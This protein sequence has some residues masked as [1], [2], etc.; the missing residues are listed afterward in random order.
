M[1]PVL[2]RLRLPAVL[3][4]LILAVY[5]AQAC[6]D[7]GTSPASV[8]Q[9]AVSPAEVQLDALEAT[10]QLEAAAFDESGDDVPGVT[11]TWSSSDESVV[12]VDDSGLLT[13]VGQGSATVTAEARGVSGTASV[14]VDQIVTTVSLTP[15]EASVA[16]GQSVDFDA[17]ASDENGHP[18]AD[19]L[20]TWTSSDDA[21]ATVDDQGV[22]TGVVAGTATI[23]AEAASGAFEEAPLTVTA[24]PLQ[25]S[26]AMVS[27]DG[28]TDGVTA[29]DFG[30]PLVVEVTDPDGAPVE[31]VD[32]S[33]EVTES[34]GSLSATSTTT[35]AAGRASVTL[36]GDT[37]LATHRVEAHVQGATGSPVAFT[38]ET[39]IMLI[40]I[41]DN[42][43]RDL[44]GRTNTDA[45]VTV[46]VGT[47][48]RWEYLGSQSSIHTVTSGAGAGG[49]SGSGVPTGGTPLD[50]GNLSP[51]DVFTATM[52]A[53]GEWTYFCQ[54]HPNIMYDAKVFVTE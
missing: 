26:L 39:S 53:A 54:I 8:A 48:V 51:G 27:G 23:R 2:R 7:D 44:Q 41:V 16:A 13:A 21:V 37:A 29:R 17:S 9:V 47:T 12:T 38:A 14:T 40:E 22:A 15:T 45:Q 28:Q 46:P 33:W 19:A 20:F 34:E 4:T 18:V 30:D 32:V 10:T 11:F 25:L 50:S 24:A 3:L 31:G 5:Q 36:T 6:G 52:D 49:A 42:A 1:T 43:F 35:D